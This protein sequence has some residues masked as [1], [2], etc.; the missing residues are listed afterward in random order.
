MYAQADGDHTRVP[1]SQGKANPALVA[2][3]NARASGVIRCGARV[4]VVGCGLGH[5]AALLADRGY[6]VTAFDA[7]PQAI[8]SAKRLHAGHE[9]DFRVADV[10]TPPSQWRHRF[11]LVVEVHILQALPPEHRAA[12]AAGMAELVAPHG[13]LLTIARGR[14]DDE[15]LGAC[16][17]P[18]YPFLPAELVELL[19][20]AGLVPDGAIDD[21]DDANTP[22]VRRLRGLWRHSGA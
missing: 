11:D 18:P 22:P 9:I 21:F 12:L 20:G 15:P 8:E 1:W 4:A 6:D 7:S 2:W 10:R 14:P 19:A 3:M 17:G 13:A 16:S 5:D